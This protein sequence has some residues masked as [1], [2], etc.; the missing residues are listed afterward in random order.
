MVLLFSLQV[1]SIYIE[2]TINQANLSLK[3]GQVE[4]L[5]TK[6][7]SGKLSFLSLR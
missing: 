3:K 2:K 1:D 7:F 6:G 5:M 4:D